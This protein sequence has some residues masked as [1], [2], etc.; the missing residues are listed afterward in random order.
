MTTHTE[1]LSSPVIADVRRSVR[2]R[3]ASAAVLV[4]LGVGCVLG[5]GCIGLLNEW[6]G[7]APYAPA[8][9]E[10]RHVYARVID[11]GI[12][13]LLLVGATMVAAWH[14][15]NWKRLAGGPRRRRG[16]PAV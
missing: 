15:A 16:H 14:A 3:F 11:A 2:F 8:V 13:A 12:C 10:A 9:T 5:V 6:A 1:T 4:A 7:A